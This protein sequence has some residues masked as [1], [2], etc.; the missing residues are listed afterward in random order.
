MWKETEI[1]DS[2]SCSSR[3]IEKVTL[4]SSRGHEV[5]IIKQKFES[6]RTPEEYRAG[7][8]SL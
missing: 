4:T 3:K 8:V 7:L 2:L 5:S 1:E 6:D